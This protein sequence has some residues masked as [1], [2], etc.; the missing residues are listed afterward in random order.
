MRI[1][2][3]YKSKAYRIFEP[4]ENPRVGGSNPPQ[5]TIKSADFINHLFIR[6]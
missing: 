1:E 2:A 5:G 3:I 6:V 4:I